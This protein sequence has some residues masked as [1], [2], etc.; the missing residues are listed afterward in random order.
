LDYTVP[1]M[2]VVGDSLSIPVNVYNT[3]Q[4]TDLNVRLALLD[5]SFEFAE[6]ALPAENDQFLLAANEQ[7]NR[8]MQLQALN[9]STNTE[10]KAYVQV[11]GQATSTASSR[12][13]LDSLLK[14]FE[15]VSPG[16]Q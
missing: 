7:A 8:T 16:V 4:E 12:R 15:V 1:Q 3:F 13:Y 10:D 9:I 14:E 11:R 6:A 2:M 5:Y